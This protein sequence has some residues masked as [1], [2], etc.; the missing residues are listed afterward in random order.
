MPTDQLWWRQFYNWSSLLPGDPS[1]CQ[2]DKTEHTLLSPALP[3]LWR[4]DH[5]TFQPKMLFFILTRESDRIS[6]CHLEE[7]CHSVVNLS[8]LH[9]WFY[10]N[11]TALLT[12][13]ICQE[14]SFLELGG[15]AYTC[16]L[17][18][19]GARGWDGWVQGQP[20]EHHEFCLR[21]PKLKQNQILFSKTKWCFLQFPGF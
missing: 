8:S 9:H 19:C 11:L 1:L 7:Q 12:G 14:Y 4:W 13:L 10:K 21:K 16:N 6:V 18:I 20:E 17:W 2:V 5:R 3:W 15:V